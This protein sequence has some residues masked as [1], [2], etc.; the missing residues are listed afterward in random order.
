MRELYENIPRVSITSRGRIIETTI[1]SGLKEK[2]PQL[3]RRE[4]LDHQHL[5]IMDTRTRF[6]PGCTVGRGS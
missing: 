4:G 6:P 1:E 5:L 3:L 2:P